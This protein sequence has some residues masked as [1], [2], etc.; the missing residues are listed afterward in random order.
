VLAAVELDQLAQGLAAQPWLVVGW[1][2]SHKPASIIQPR[3]VSRETLSPC[4]SRSLSVARVGPKS[5]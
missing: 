1:R 3:S 5:A 4:R 2:E